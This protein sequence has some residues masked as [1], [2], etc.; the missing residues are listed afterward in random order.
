MV[1]KF[2]YFDKMWLTL[3]LRMTCFSLISTKHYHFVIAR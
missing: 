1:T 3:P 2:G